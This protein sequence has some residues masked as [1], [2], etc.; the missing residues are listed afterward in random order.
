M[1]RKCQVE[2]C[3]RRVY[4]NGWLQFMYCTDHGCNK[5]WCQLDHHE[6]CTFSKDCAYCEQHCDEKHGDVDPAD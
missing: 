6:N 3:E 5:G 2:G 4:Q 1:D